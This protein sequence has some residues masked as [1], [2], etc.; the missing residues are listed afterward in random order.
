MQKGG[1]KC[2]LA[3]PMKIGTRCSRDTFSKSSLKENIV[4]FSR[5][6]SGV[7]YFT[8]NEEAAGSLSAVRQGILSTIHYELFV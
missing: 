3:V 8:W 1:N 5:K 2:S 4:A 7:G 6:L